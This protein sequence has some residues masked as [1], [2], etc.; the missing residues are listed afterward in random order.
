MKRLICYIL[1][2]VLLLANCMPVLADG[3]GDDQRSDYPEVVDYRY[4][5]V[6]DNPA[7]QKPTA[8]F[9]LQIKDAGGNLRPET[10]NS[11]NIDDRGSIVSS[12]DSPVINACIGDSIV[13]KDRSKVGSGSK[14]TQYDIQYRFTPAGQNR[15]DYEIHPAV[16]SSWSQ[17]KNIIEN[18]P[19]DQPGTYEI[20]MAVADDAPCLPGATNWSA[21]GNVRSVNMNNPNF[22]G[23][24]FW[25]FTCAVVEVTDQPGL[26]IG[27]ELTPRQPYWQI[28]VDLGYVHPVIDINFT[29]NIDDHQLPIFADGYKEAVGVK[30]EDFQMIKFGGEPPMRELFSFKVT[31]PGRYV[32]RAGIPT[33]DENGNPIL[34]E[35]D[36]EMQPDINPANN[37]DEIVI[38]VGIGPPSQNKTI[39]DID[40]GY[41]GGDHIRGDLTG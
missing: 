37:H 33:E 2:A 36:R 25:Y 24:I 27:V 4:H 38:E 26:D 30:S 14:I 15:E 1:T 20:Y 21:N 12:Q 29:V 11:G 22:P 18:L 16:V 34:F 5:I 40:T 10:I 9:A 32:I 39:P 6:S 19:L 23:G 41:T 3:I 28:P 8:G 31:Q 13:I 17:V 7:H 35:I